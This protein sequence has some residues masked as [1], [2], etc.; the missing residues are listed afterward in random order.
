MKAEFSRV[1]SIFGLGQ[2]NSY[3]FPTENKERKGK[4]R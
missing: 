3:T 2:L 1:R 4:T